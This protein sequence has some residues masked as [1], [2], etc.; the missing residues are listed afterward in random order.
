MKRFSAI[1]PLDGRYKD[2]MNELSEIFSEAGLTQY[3]VMVE[4]EYLIRLFSS[5]YKIIERNL[6]EK[7]VL[8]LRS[9]YKD[10][11]TEDMVIIKTIEEKGYN[12]RPAT[13]HDVKAVE[14]FIKDKLANSSLQDY[15]EWV[16]FG[17]TSED[18]NNIA[19]ALMLSDAVGEIILPAI[20]N[21]EDKLHEMIKRYADKPMLSRT[22][23]Q[24]AS[25]TTVGKELAVFEGR[26]KKQI[27][28]LSQLTL[29]AKLN[30]ATG[31][32]NAHFA[33][34]PEVPW[35]GFSWYF[36]QSF[37]Y[38]RNVCR[39]K[40]NP[41]TTQIESTDSYAELF[42]ILARINTIFLGFVQDMW[43]YISDGWFIEQR[44]GVGSSTMPHKVNPIN[45]ENAEGNL[46]M[47]N[48]LFEY[49]SRKLPVS[50]LQRDLSDSTVKRNFGVAFG[51]SLLAY[52]SILSGLNKV[53]VDENNLADALDNHWEILSELIQTILRR[54]GVQLPYEKLK[55]L[56]KDKKVTRKI[57]H[58]FILELEVSDEVKEELL[59]YTPAKYIGIAPKLAESI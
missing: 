25:P 22:H 49:F 12:G 59:S 46:G 38:G 48:A 26:L 52:K 57:L 8:F 31:N 45:F 3:R 29:S 2:K 19:Y 21:I 44:E 51:W 32:Y 40:E 11:S 27:N 17:L 15:I 30:G 39:L 43:R 37:N 18:I 9:I 55:A 41:L 6:T 53:S 50:R 13:Y 23:G 24:S 36:I 1:G 4:V 5:Q 16:H 7:E 58:K 33:A 47:A 54:E 28:N 42:D 14:Y 10:F 56:T 20:G 35:E 34:Y